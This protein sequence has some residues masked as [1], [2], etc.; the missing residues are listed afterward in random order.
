V[1]VAT[2]VILHAV[3]HHVTS[4]FHQKYYKNLL[5]N[6][7]RPEE[8]DEYSEELHK[9]KRYIVYKDP[10]NQT[11]ISFKGK[12]LEMEEGYFYCPNIPEG[13]LTEA[14]SEKSPEQ[15]SSPFEERI[16]SELN[17]NNS[18]G[19]SDVWGIIENRYKKD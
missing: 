6:T 9:A 7:D 14:L 12:E 3:T 4:I 2:K 17:K 19:I 11:P 10:S 15:S 16:K 1:Y 13:L 18:G 5:T 8:L